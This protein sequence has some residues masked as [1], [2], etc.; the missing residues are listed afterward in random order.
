[1]AL[2]KKVN[3]V[4]AIRDGKISSERIL[5]EKFVDRVKESDINWREEETQE[6]F[7]ILDKANRVQLPPELLTELKL[8]DNKVKLAV[9]DGEIIISRPEK[10]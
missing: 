5:K 7:A 9:K 2:S 4:V 6:E 1:M 10:G 3:R 8:E